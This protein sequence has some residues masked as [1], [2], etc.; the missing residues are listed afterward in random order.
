MNGT[1]F[2]LRLYALTTGAL[3]PFAPSL[4]QG[5]VRGGKEDEARLGE[6]LG[7]SAAPHP[8]RPVAWLHGASVGEA[9]SLLPLIERL[10]TERPD[11]AVLATS[12][13]RTS[14]ELMAKRLPADA[15]HQYVPIDTPAATR[16]FLDHWRP[17][18][19]VFVESELWPNLLLG[20]RRRGTRLALLSARLSEKS[21]R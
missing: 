2:S 3:S 11:L 4:L 20:A 5:R 10:A 16:A 12:G 9:L 7:R 19:G 21:R 17:V 13:T 6:R 15:I 1:P 14:A 8:G 18:L